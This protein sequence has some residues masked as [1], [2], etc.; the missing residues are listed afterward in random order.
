MV[1]ENSKIPL[2]K[3]RKEKSD[4]K[5]AKKRREIS[6]NGR[7][8]LIGIYTY[9]YTCTCSIHLYVSIAASVYVAITIILSCLVLF[10]ICTHAVI[11]GAGTN[12]ESGVRR[13]TRI[14]CRP[15]EF[16]KG[17]KLLYGRVHKS[18]YSLFLV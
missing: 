17:E 6:G 11:L 7:K 10:N 12:W 13:S 8:S 3:K 14:R 2:S 16:W 1:E 18:E 9:T 5:K 4:L 15:L